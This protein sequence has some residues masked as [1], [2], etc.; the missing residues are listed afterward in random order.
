MEFDVVVVGAGP[1]GLAAA[2][3][4]ASSLAP[5][6]ARSRFASSRRARPIGSHI[7][8]GAVFDPRRSP[9]YSPTGVARGAPFGTPVVAERCDWL[10]RGLRAR[11]AR[12]VVPR[13]LRNPATAS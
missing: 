1:A 3:R 4:L 7:V 8:S 6:T 5:E 2:C 11:G 10:R 9:S 13:A 12:C